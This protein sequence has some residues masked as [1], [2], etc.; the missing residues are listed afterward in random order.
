MPLEA[1]SITFVSVEP[2]YHLGNQKLRVP[3]R[4]RLEKPVREIRRLKEGRVMMKTNYSNWKTSLWRVLSKAKIP[5]MLP[6][7]LIKSTLPPWAQSYMTF[8]ILPA[9]RCCHA[10]GSSQWDVGR[11]W[12]GLTDFKEMSK[13][14]PLGGTFCFVLLSSLSVLQHPLPSF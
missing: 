13:S 3:W 6:N 2:K 11:S 9:V 4:P 7:I 12:R 5:T 1:L 8:P 14:L 10:L